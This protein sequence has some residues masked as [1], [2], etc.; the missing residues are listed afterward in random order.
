MDT[1][2]DDYESSDLDNNTDGNENSDTQYDNMQKSKL[3]E[4]AN[5]LKLAEFSAKL[6]KGK[7]QKRYWTD[8][9]VSDPNYPQNLPLCSSNHFVIKSGR[10]L[11]SLFFGAYE[12]SFYKFL[13][14]ICDAICSSELTKSLNSLHSQLS[15][16][17]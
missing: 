15:S 4:H 6:T 8:Q 9:E 17:S 13:S 1:V 11:V 12:S 2:K 5:A 3:V 16:N 7:P 10:W 14:R